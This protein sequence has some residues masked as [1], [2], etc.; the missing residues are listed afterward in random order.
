MAGRDQA[1][2][3][4]TCLESVQGHMFCVCMRCGCCLHRGTCRAR[5]GRGQA[6]VSKQSYVLSQIRTRRC[7][8]TCCGCPLHRGMCRA[9]GG[10]DEPGPAKIRPGVAG[11]VAEGRQC[12]VVLQ[13]DGYSGYTCIWL[14]SVQALMQVQLRERWQTL[15]VQCHQGP[16]SKGTPTRKGWVIG[17]LAALYALSELP[18]THTKE[19]R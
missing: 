13:T 7:V 19:Q 1:G 2:K 8:C 3:A 12:V 6:G 5:A 18:P 17:A 9:R 10:R 11:N 15:I 16:W 14:T 4:I